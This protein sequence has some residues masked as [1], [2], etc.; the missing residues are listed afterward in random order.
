MIHDVATFTLYGRDDSP[1]M[2]VTISD[3]GRDGCCFGL[4]LCSKSDEFS[5]QT[6]R[7]K[8]LTKV[9]RNSHN[10]AFRTP[11][12][13]A[14]IHSLCVEDF[15]KLCQFMETVIAPRSPFVASGVSVLKFH[16]AVTLFNSQVKVA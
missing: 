5:H 16:K 4:A 11:R 3:D 10:E 13:L 7:V 9:V 12:A 14:L 8:S 15:S 2:K 6:G 1:R